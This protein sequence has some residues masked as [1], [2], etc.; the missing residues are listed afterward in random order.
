[1]SAGFAQK[2]KAYFRVVGDGILQIIRPQ[3][4][5]VFRSDVV[6][7]GLLSM[8]DYLMPQHFT[9]TGSITRYPVSNC[10]AF[11]QRPLAFYPSAELQLD[12][13]HNKVIPWL[14]TI[15]TQKQLINAISRLDPR[16]NDSLK[17]IP[18]L[19]CGEIN[20]ARKV[21][22]EILRQHD[23]AYARRLAYQD[24]PPPTLNASHSESDN[25]LCALIALMEKKDPNEIRACLSN[26]YAQNIIYA[27]F[28]CG[29]KT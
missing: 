20:H 4:E 13:L 3:Y 26:N 6:Y 14:N 2:G 11:D 21:A 27:K 17:I 5:R 24:T 7:I 18:Y 23:F 8:Y 12:L 1:M 15:N 16:W 9:S 25:R 19:A 28:C 10:A 22:K 29:D